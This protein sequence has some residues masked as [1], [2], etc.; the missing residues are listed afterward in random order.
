M[1][2]LSAAQITNLMPTGSAIGDD[3]ILKPRC[4]H[5]RQ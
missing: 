5:R 2:R 4:A 1:D 3:E